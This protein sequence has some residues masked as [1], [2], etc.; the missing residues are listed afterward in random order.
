MMI[1]AY[2]DKVLIEHYESPEH[3]LPCAADDRSQ[4]GYELSRLSRDECV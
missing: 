4:Y 1:E 2:T 3:S